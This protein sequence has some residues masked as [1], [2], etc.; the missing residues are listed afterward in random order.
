MLISL[1]SAY[2]YALHNALTKQKSV[3]IQ[4]PRS[5]PLPRFCPNPLYGGG[6]LKELPYSAKPPHRILCLDIDNHPVTPSYSEVFL[7]WKFTTIIEWE[8]ISRKIFHSS[9]FLK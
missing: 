4:S 6:G 5:G 8:Q 2:I 7:L 9:S 3:E 1:N